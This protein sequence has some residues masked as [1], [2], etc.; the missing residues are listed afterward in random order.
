MGAGRSPHL[1]ARDDLRRA[2]TRAAG[3]V[4]GRPVSEVSE[5]PSPDLTRREAVAGAIL[6]VSGLA[7]GASACS[8][9]LEKGFFTAGEMDV[10]EE[11]CETI[12]PQTGTPG[13]RAA[14]VHDFIDGMMT[15]WASATTQAATRAVLK[16]VDDAGGGRFARLGE[17]GRAAIVQRLDAAAFAAEDKAWAAFKKLVLLGSYTSEIGA[18]QELAYLPVPGDWKADVKLTPDMRAW[19]E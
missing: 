9:P 3:T 11:L 15:T 16:R 13:A 4:Y 12:L 5:R 6:L 8:R 17:G 7:L 10:L 14:K 1:P 19:A 2:V 18:T